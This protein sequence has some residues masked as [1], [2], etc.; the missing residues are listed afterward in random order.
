[1]SS[2]TFVADSTEDKDDQLIILVNADGTITVDSET[3]SKL[4]ANQ[5]HG[6]NLSIVRVGDGNVTPEDAQDEGEEG[7]HVNLTVEGYYSGNEAEILPSDGVDAS[8]EVVDPFSQMEPEHIARLESVLQSEQA[9]EILG[10]NLDDNLNSM[11][12][13]L[14]GKDEVPRSAVHND[15]SYTTSLPNYQQP[16]APPQ[17]QP[18][19]PQTQPVIQHRPLTRGG[20]GRGRGRGLMTRGGSRGAPQSQVAAV[21]NTPVIVQP[22][23]TPKVIQASPQKTF[24]VTQTQRVITQ[25]AILQ[26]VVTQPVVVEEVVEQQIPPP[27]VVSPESTP[28]IIQRKLIVPKPQPQLQPKP[29]LKQQTLQQVLL[30]SQVPQ[31]GSSQETGRVASVVRAGSQPII[32]QK[33]LVTVRGGGRGRGGRG[34]GRGGRGRQ[35]QQPPPI[36]APTTITPEGGDDVSAALQA[37]ELSPPLPVSLAP[38]PQ[39]VTTQPVTKVQTLE[40]AEKSPV[41]KRKTTP[42]VIIRKIGSRSEIVSSPT[43]KANKVRQHDESE[44]FAPPVIQQQTAVKVVKQITLPKPTEPPI[45]SARGPTKEVPTPSVSTPEEISLKKKKDKKASV[46]PVIVEGPELFSTPDIIR[47]V[48]TDK[49]ADVLPTPTQTPHVQV[50]PKVQVQP[51]HPPLTPTNC[52]SEMS[53][54]RLLD[55]IHEEAAKDGSRLLA[56]ALLL[57]DLTN[58]D[59]TSMTYPNK[60]K[61]ETEQVMSGESL[62]QQPPQ[63]TKQTPPKPPPPKPIE[64]PTPRIRKLPPIELPTTRS[65]SKKAAATN[66]PTVTVL[67]QEQTQVQSPVSTKVGGQKER[68]QLSAGAINE[69]RQSNDSKKVSE[70]KY[71]LKEDF[72]SDFEEGESDDESWNSEDDPDRLWCICKKPHN[73]RFMICCD[74]CEEWFHGKC[75]G[76]TKAMGQQMELEGTEWS[77]P[78]CRNKT[79]NVNAKATQETKHAG[80]AP[81]KLPPGQQTISSLECIACK[82][83]ARVG[84]NYCSDVCVR[85][86]ALNMIGALKEEVDGLQ[87]TTRVIVYEKKTGRIIAD[88]SAPTVSNLA[89]WLLENQTFE[90][91]KPSISSKSYKKNV[92]QETQIS[93]NNQVKRLP[94][95]LQ[96]DVKQ[97][98]VQLKQQQLPQAKQMQQQQLLKQ[99]ALSSKQLPQPAQG[100]LAQQSPAKQAH[101]SAKVQQHLTKAQPVTPKQIGAEKPTLKQTVLT[102]KLVSATKEVTYSPKPS[103]TPKIQMIQPQPLTPTQL[104]KSKTNKE[105]K[106]EDD[107]ESKNR[108]S[109]KSMTGQIH[110]ERTKRSSMDGKKQTSEKANLKEEKRRDSTCI[111]E[112]ME[113]DEKKKKEEKKKEKKKDID[114]S[115]KISEESTSTTTVQSGEPVR[116]NVKRTIQELLSQRVKEDTSL[117]ITDDEVNELATSIE[118]EMFALFNKDTGAKYRTKYRSLVFNIKDQ[119]NLTL[120][121]KIVT[122]S[123]SPDQLVRLSPEELASQE[124]A[125]WRE[126]E[127]KHQLEIIKKNELDLIHQAKTVVLKS[128]KGEEVIESKVV[129]I[130]E[131]ES[132]LNRTADDD[133]VESIV[134]SATK[135]EEKLLEKLLLDKKYEKDKEERPSR[136]SERR[137]KSKDE[138]KKDRSRSH[139]RKRS[140]SKSHDRDKRK[141]DKDKEKVKVKERDKAEE[142]LK[143]IEEVISQYVPTLSQA[144]DSDQSDREPSSTVNISTPPLEEEKPP[145]WQGYL[146]MTEVTKLYTSAYEVSGSCEDLGEE[147]SDQLDCVG[148]IQPDSVWEYVSRMKK[149]GTK[150]I[151][152]IRFQSEAMEE[153]MNYLSLYSYLNSRNRMA[154]IGQTS[155]TVKDFYVLPLASH[156][157]IP[158]VLLPL[159]GPGFDDYRTHLLLGI[160]I[161]TKKG[162]A[163]NSSLA[164]SNRNRKPVTV[165]ST[166]NNLLERSYTPPL[167][168]T[169]FV[170]SGYP[171]S[172]LPDSGST[173]PP[174]PSYKSFSHTSGLTPPLPDEDEP[175]SPGEPYSPEDSQTEAILVNPDIQRNLE[176]VNRMIEQKRQQIKSIA[177]AAAHGSVSVDE[178]TPYSPSSSFTPP[179]QDNIPFLDTNEIKLPPNLQDILASI[180]GTPTMDVKSDPIVKAYTSQSYYDDEDDVREDERDLRGERT[181]RDPRQR[182]EPKPKSALSQ[183]TDSDLIRKA[184]E[185]ESEDKKES[186]KA[187]YYYPPPPPPPPVPV[188]PP[189]PIYGPP[190]PSHYKY[191]SA[192]PPPVAVPPP[193]IVKDRKRKDKFKERRPP[194]MP[195]PQ[196]R[197]WDNG[198]HHRG[199]MMTPHRPPL[200]GRQPRYRGGFERGRGGGGFRGRGGFRLHR[201][202]PPPRFDRGHNRERN[203]QSE[204][205]EEIRNFEQRKARE[206]KRKASRSPSPR[207]RSLSPPRRRSRRASSNSS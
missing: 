3:L 102:P 33:K 179:R 143:E 14:E 157:P 62:N 54:E 136:S 46:L 147:L 162:T 110:Q 48:S 77:C 195:H 111:K 146:N 100:T 172:E 22:S 6:N 160:I 161:R 125:Q 159:D 123:I 2:S 108:K 28:R 158:Q 70:K 78:N 76:V 198:A 92:T 52:D 106:K 185:M 12:D 156:S 167:P 135:D 96:A 89:D 71:S 177:Q 139:S 171:D 56:E 49:Q 151:V 94:K 21:T 68:K 144:I 35:P 43:G 199:G 142:T 5:H 60:E 31:V 175:Y 201:G 39:T 168:D 196:R 90:V 205:D 17:Q 95:T 1:M 112:T 186:F 207:R 105:N 15:H 25:P 150:D 124:L 20:R 24:I 155:K 176:E 11:L 169:G 9:K 122:K 58:D 67:Q 183:F 19:Q 184:A 193:P 115:S 72:V 204:W 103:T 97:S 27:P 55:S 182:P 61:R 74:G 153:K 180:K 93:P 118:E 73:N 149:A 166:T 10:T 119:K 4:I 99:Q 130:S 63:P 23:P 8:N 203:V 197:K 84:S 36:P 134:S 66:Q 191:P 41:V 120:Y 133:Q 104:P 128:R 45:P 86:H 107:E 53:A 137:K 38:Q 64:T 30:S 140:R 85:R 50:E 88:S 37:M 51:T 42:A 116:A 47:R 181:S 75:V 65:A 79:E 16:Q 29:L 170:D 81:A 98:Q 148:R 174:L 190:P 194:P 200:R 178:E 163:P 138:R 188:G 129:N 80:T 26:P 121:K 87:P 192:P 127:A 44:Q 34:V 202:G 113:K 152:V 7:P 101:Q 165:S 13:I 91:H 57:D 206:R 117:S 40:E 145:V 59:S 131:I 154:V 141:K 18:V 32:I 82:K 189:P 83:P 173:T 69:K 114:E 109:I 132:A 126:K 164:L 187:S